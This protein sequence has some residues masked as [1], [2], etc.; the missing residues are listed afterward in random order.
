MQNCWKN[1]RSPILRYLCEATI[2]AI[3]SGD[4]RYYNACPNCPKKIRIEGDNFYCD[5]CSIENKGYK[6]RYMIVVSVKDDS[7]KTTFTLFNKDVKRLLGIPIERL[8]ADIGQENLTQNIPP[9]LN[10]IVGKKCTFHI[11][12]NSF[13]QG[14][15]AG[16]TVA[17]LY[18]I[19]T[20]LPNIQPP[21]PSAESG[22]S[23]KKK[24]T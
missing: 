17:R 20:Q 11:K 9:L 16:Y 4:D 14:G 13:N 8:V 21:T 2:V 15:R 22:P 1:H 12:V 6:E 10:N 5:N 18:E 24:T 23:K 7:G 19:V 3:S